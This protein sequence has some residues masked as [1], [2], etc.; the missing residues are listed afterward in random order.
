MYIVIDSLLSIMFSIKTVAAFYNFLF[1]LF[2]STPQ[3]STE[4]R[5]R[6]SFRAY[7][8]DLCPYPS[9]PHPVDAQLA[10]SAID[11]YS[12]V[13]NSMSS[14]HS[15]VHPASLVP[16]HSTVELGGGGGYSES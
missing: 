12:E 4:S 5:M 7:L 16:A 6:I 13:C 1:N 11:L 8:F 2:K 3:K 10:S 14:A 15:R 9:G